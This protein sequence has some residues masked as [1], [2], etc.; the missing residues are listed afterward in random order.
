MNLSINSF[1]SG[2]MSPLL[3]ARSDTAK[4]ASGCKRLEN[5][6][7]RVS[8]AII[9]RPGM[10]HLAA[11]RDETKKV[12]IVGLNF[13]VQDSVVLEIGHLY[14]RVIQSDGT[15]L[16]LDDTFSGYDPV[17]GATVNIGGLPTSH[18]I[19]PWTEDHLHEL[20]FCQVNDLI[21]VVH[22]AYPPQR[23]TR[24]AI[25][26]YIIDEIQW[27]WP[28]FADENITE[29]TLALSGTALTASDAV[30]E[31]SHVGAYFELNHRRESQYVETIID[32]ETPNTESKACTFSEVNS[33][34][35]VNVPAHGWPI[36]SV[37]KFTTNNTLPPGIEAGKN[38]YI[39]GEGLN[40]NEFYISDAIS[41]N[42][43]AYEKY[44]IEVDTSDWF[45]IDEIS[46]SNGQAVQISSNGTL[47]APLVANATYYV[48]DYERLITIKR[49]RLAATLGGGAINI[50]SAGSGTHFLSKNQLGSASVIRNLPYPLAAPA[51]TESS[52]SGL[53]VYGRASVFTFGA[54]DGT[55]TLKRM[56]GPATSEVV[57]SW[58]S[59]GDRNLSVEIEQYPEA[60]LFL[61]VVAHKVPPQREN[62]TWGRDCRFIL[63]AGDAI[64]TGLVQV[65]SVASAT[66]AQVMVISPTMN[67][68]AT[69]QW[70][71]GAWSKRRGYPRSI[72]LHQQRLF[73]AGTTYD[74]QTIWGSAIGDFQ[75]FRRSTLD[76]AAVSFTVA[77]TEW[78]LIQWITSNAG[79]II[80]GT[81]GDEWTITAEGNAIT[82]TNVQIKRQS[83]YGSGYRQAL[84]VNEVVLFIQRGGRKL[85]EH[86]FSFERDG[87][88]APDLTLLADHITRGSVRSMALMQQPDSIVWMVRNDG[89]LLGM[90]YER[91]QQVVAW[92][93]HP[94]AGEV[95][96]VATI[97][98]ANG[99]ELW[100][101]VKRGSRRFIERLDPQTMRANESSEDATGLCYLDSSLIQE[102]AEP[103]A[104][105][106]GISHL[107]G[108]TVDV[109]ADGETHPS[110]VVASSFITLEAPALN[111]CVGL[112][113]VSLA[114]VNSFEVPMS[115]GSSKSRKWRANRAVLYC[116]Q[117][118]NAQINPNAADAN[119]Q[120]ENLIF[121][122]GASP[123]ECAL[124]SRYD[125]APEIALR[126]A[127]PLPLNVTCLVVK[128]DWYGD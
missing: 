73:F 52:T 4:H 121:S 28:A 123:A 96:S 48:R 57:Q 115:N 85:R 86:V 45:E 112:P 90:T 30:F 18:R 71:E 24:H 8:G 38:Y 114:H 77:T 82:A 31:Q 72:V 80:V 91:D 94:T 63:E 43:I 20:Q 6:I 19:S 92:H 39:I 107:N 13:G 97:Y 67:A 128:G 41:G 3:Q 58:T 127:L 62:E 49:F 125:E 108:Q 21:F 99:D 106:V 120:W 61:E 113:F 35:R 93:R 14:F 44:V 23:I 89:L 103:V 26:Q 1:N 122:F 70:S 81:S 116:W 29:T 101:V 117:S 42:P 56:T 12:I 65:T 66:S 37:V 87:Y 111:A 54:W 55:V 60:E 10:R 102:A 95:E 59:K 88:I 76:D 98:G 11:C 32:A 75:N 51:N 74:P 79:G 84:P 110:R 105:V 25:N 53:R 78:N 5:F 124:N 119:E 36:D 16:V 34:L 47:A 33:K 40:A 83:S 100:L 126:Q 46:L 27:D 104:N 69:A 15:V 9:R 68:S 118:Q 109:L 64:L 50:T 7:P 17:T 22:P 2:E